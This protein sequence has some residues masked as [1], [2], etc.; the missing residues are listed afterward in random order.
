MALDG[1]R[2]QEILPHAASIPGVHRIKI[3]CFGVDGLAQAGERFFGGKNG[4]FI[5]VGHSDWIRVLRKKAQVEQLL[6]GER[7]SLR[8]VFGGGID[9]QLHAFYG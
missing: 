4:G 9:H 5:C 7:L 8:V 6:D 2:R 3:R 1:N